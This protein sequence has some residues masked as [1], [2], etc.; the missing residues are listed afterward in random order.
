MLRWAAV[1]SRSS[2]IRELEQLI[3]KKRSVMAQRSEGEKQQ[4]VKALIPRRGE[5]CIQKAGRYTS[6][7]NFTIEVVCAVESPPQGPA[8]SGF[9]YQI[10]TVLADDMTET[11]YAS[12]Q[13]MRLIV[14]YSESLKLLT[15]T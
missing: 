10:K 1:I 9:I 4:R 11:R 13:Q 3:P 2:M 5:I 12:L 7:T 8:M 15:A 6:C 14:Q